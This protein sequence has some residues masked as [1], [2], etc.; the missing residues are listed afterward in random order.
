M[1]RFAHT[2]FL[3]GLAF[4]PLLVLLFFAVSSWKTKALAAFGDKEVIRTMMPEVSFSR[5]VVK[6][7]FFMTAYA[8]LIIGLADPQI[9]TKTEDTKTRAPT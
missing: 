7:I 8:L 4:I 2:E 3:W 6:F 9:G 5:P 1:L